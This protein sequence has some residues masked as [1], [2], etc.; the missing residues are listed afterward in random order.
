MS[1]GDMLTVIVM[2]L[3]V[4][5]PTVYLTLKQYYRKQIHLAAIERGHDLPD[6]PPARQP[7]LRRPALILMALGLGFSIATFVTISLASHHSGPHPAAVSIW[8]IVPILLG[9]ALWLY[10]ARISDK[11]S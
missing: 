6:D 3:L 5:A 10:Q 9:A 2:S 4:L 7:D 11:N 1:S 8:G